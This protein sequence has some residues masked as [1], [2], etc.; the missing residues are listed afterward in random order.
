MRD[1]STWIAVLILA[2]LMLP[3]ALEGKVPRRL[4]RGSVRVS[5]VIFWAMM[6]SPILAILILLWVWLNGY[7]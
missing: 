4:Y 2:L 1:E 5:S 3:V 7:I 6:L